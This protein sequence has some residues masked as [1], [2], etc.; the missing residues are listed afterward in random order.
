MNSEQP[1]VSIITA[2]HN[3]LSV[4][5]IYAKHLVRHTRG[6]YELIV[7][8]NAS[9]DGSAEYFEDVGARVLRNTDNYS[10]PYTQNQ[11]V[12]IARGEVFAFLNNDLLVGPGWDDILL[13]HMDAGGV[14]VC[15]ASGIEGAADAAETRRLKRRWK[16]IKNPLLAL[17]GQRESALWLMQ[18]LMYGDWSNFCAS[19]AQR[20]AGQHTEGMVGCAVFISRRGWDKVGS[21]D[22]RLQAADYDLYLRSVDRHLTHGD[23]QPMQVLHDLY[24]HHYI[25]LTLKARKHPPRFA[26][27]ANLVRLQDKWPSDKLD[28]LARLGVDHRSWR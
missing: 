17:G 10:Y 5:R 12:A 16:L 15:C 2:V 21:W 25:R 9:S 6:P 23:I 28:Y 26:D 27:A 11:G 24:M 14:D 3:Q 1:R 7:I 4:N 8:D 19:R 13:Q 20:F 18:R 22:E